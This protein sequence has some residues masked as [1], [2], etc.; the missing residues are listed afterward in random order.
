MFDQHSI[1]A[2]SLGEEII[3]RDDQLGSYTSINWILIP[4]NNKKDR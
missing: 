1:S 3:N 2:F 4:K